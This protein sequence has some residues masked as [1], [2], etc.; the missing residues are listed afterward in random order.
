M[1]IGAMAARL[2]ATLCACAVAGY[3]AGRC[4]CCGR[5]LTLLLRS[6]LSAY[7]LIFALR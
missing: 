4:L 1:G 6:L 2:I 5:V 3:N 7:R